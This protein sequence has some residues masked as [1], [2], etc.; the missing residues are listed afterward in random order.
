MNVIAGPSTPQPGLIGFASVFAALIVVSLACIVRNVQQ[1]EKEWLTS[2]LPYFLLF[3]AILALVGVSGDIQHA[4]AFFIYA[5]SAFGFSVHNFQFS[6]REYY[7]NGVISGLLTGL[8]LTYVGATLAFSTGNVANHNHSAFWATHGLFILCWG[9]VCWAKARSR[10]KGK[11]AN[12]DT[13]SC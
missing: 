4:V 9:L 2:R 6:Q 10:H 7:V 13:D 11:Q 1:P 8:L 12:R 5:A 3:I